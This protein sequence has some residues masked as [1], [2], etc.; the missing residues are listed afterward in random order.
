MEMLVS[1]QSAMVSI[2]LGKEKGRT[3]IGW[4]SVAMVAWF[5]M[6]VQATV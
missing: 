1:W 3:S 2:F 4:H 6:V 5:T